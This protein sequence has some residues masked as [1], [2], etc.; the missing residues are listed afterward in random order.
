MNQYRKKDVLLILFVL[1]FIS[2][3]AQYKSIDILTDTA[4]APTTVPGRLFNTDSINNTTSVAT[5]TGNALNK[6]TV[7]NLSNALAGQLPGLFTIQGTGEPGNDNAS[8]AIRGIGSYGLGFYNSAKIFVDGF[9][10]NRNYINYLSAMEIENVSIF[11]D[12]AALAT[13]GMRGANG[14]IWIETK[15]GNIGPPKVT[16][17]ARS[18]IQQPVNI[19]K[20]L[21]ASDFASLYNQAISND[22]GAWTP[23]Y[24]QAQLQDY[25]NG[26]GTNVDWY[27]EVLRDKGRYTDVDVMFNGG[28]DKAR[29]NVV[30]GHASQ[31][32]LYNVENTDQTS[33][34]RMQRFNIRGNLDFNLFK[35]IDASVDIGGRLENRRQPNYWSVMNDLANYPSNIYPVHDT[36][37]TED[38]S[39]FSG[40]AL[41]PNN[42]VGSISGLGWYSSRARTLQ[43]NFRLRERLD[44]ITKGL[45]LQESFSFY[46]RSVS[47]YSKTRNYARYFNG[48]PT[49]TDQTTSIVASNYGTGGMDQWKQGSIGLGYENNFGKS[50][51]NSGFNFHISDFQ[52]EGLFEYKQ[53]YMNYS[54]RVNYSYD[55]RYT[56]EFGFSYFGS[57]AYAPGN[58][59]GFYPS[60]SAAW[61]LSNEAFLRNHQS[62]SLLKLRGSVGKSGEMVS[63]A[64]NNIGYYSDGR[65]LY[66]QY[67]NWS[68][69]YYTGVSA[70]FASGSSIR[71]LFIANPN[72]FAEQSLKYNIGAEV[73]IFHKLQLIAD[74]FMD[75]RS[76]ILTTRNSQMN[77]YGVNNYLE[78]IGEMTNKGF[79]L[80]AVYKNRINAFNY[81][82]HGMVFYA[83]NTI[84]YMDEVQPAFSYNAYTGN[85]FGTRLGL[86][87]Q[88]FYQLEDFNADGTLKSGIPMPLFGAVQPGDIRY[89]DL[90]KNGFVDQTDVTE[91]GGP[92]YPKWGYSFGLQAAYKGF[93]FSLLFQ[94]AAG[95]SVN[96][97]DYRAQFVAFVNNGNAYENAMGAWAYYPDQGIDTR[98]N[99]TYP[100]LT[101][102]NNENNYRNSSFWIRDNNYLRIKNVELGYNLTSNLL[103]W[104]G[105]SGFRIFLNAVN[106]VTFSKLLSD[107]NMDPESG[108]GYPS[109]KSYYFG[110][111]LTF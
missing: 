14:I 42:P 9:E 64:S 1:P 102:Q 55:S 70:P 25:Q 52:G 82:V 106:P 49:T 17:Q 56:G 32:G 74:V 85:S 59:W 39:N 58:R 10:V 61:I 11:K 79:E 53:R 13:F 98:A 12:A 68:T 78:N 104:N 107:Y 69:P 4:K 71:P 2:V 95:A 65:F 33:N 51:I 15:R 109:L 90:D 3:L 75:K 63:N 37:V 73:E 86:L 22:N 20:P 31:Q 89:E 6:I 93:D 105:I 66:Q 36:T 41:Y 101:T 18:G 38:E 92:G 48:A 46:V 40:T 111:R 97:L 29:Y 19:H 45:Y 80:S 23:Y 87:S 72:V 103:K 43:S 76:D 30:L 57:D 7:A 54:G 96:L 91:I 99:A 50:M 100:R 35:I 110:V 8:L 77:Y 67:Y 88:G 5:V 27:N 24:S 60:L 84:D 34:Q 28:M 16:I 83:K 44:F 94:G 26:T 62:I 81:S 108:Y 47:T 21:N